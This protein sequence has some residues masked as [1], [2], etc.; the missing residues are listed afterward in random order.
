M[1]LHVVGRF[2][3][4]IDW[5]RY[6][7]FR[8]EKA[9]DWCYG[10]IA[11]RPVKV[12]QSGGALEFRTADDVSEESLAPAVRRYFRLDEDV[13]PIHD[14]LRAEGDVMARLVAKYGGM[15]LLRQD[16]WECLVAYI[17][18]RNNTIEGITRIV[19]ALARE[20]GRPLELD[21]VR[22]NAFPSPDR[23]ADAGE[24]RLERQAPGLRRAA[25]IAAVARDVASGYL[26]L[27]ALSR[28]RLRQARS[29]L[30][31][32]DS[33]GPKIADC[34]C[35]FALGQTEA[36][37]VDGNVGAAI[38]RHYRKTY[39]PG[40]PNAGLLHWARERF[41]EHAGYASQLLFQNQMEWKQGQS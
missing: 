5:L 15:R 1:E 6:Q 26:D 19:E 32:Y 22:L 35:L 4:G 40:A 11:G 36:F 24:A 16:P 30:M 18:S 25:T 34:V 9:G 14:A 38:E 21:G 13:A 17:C 8:W 37:P 27:D 2:E 3:L 29:L 28:F 33:I 39:T 41:G 7:A 12:R 20:Y 23:L 10:V 31:S